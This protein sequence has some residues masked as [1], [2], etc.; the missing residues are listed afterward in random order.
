[1]QKPMREPLGQFRRRFDGD[2][3]PPKI[4]QGF[5]QYW[6]AALDYMHAEACIVHTGM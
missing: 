6:L 1:M 2:K 4:L 5:L 3:L